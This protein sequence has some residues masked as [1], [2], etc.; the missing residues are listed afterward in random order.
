VLTPNPSL[1]PTAANGLRALA[2]PSSLRSSAAPQRERYAASGQQAM[3]TQQHLLWVRVRRCLSER[4]VG[5]RWHK[6]LDSG[7]AQAS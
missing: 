2:V 3:L 7:E 6:G 4:T 1:E 5:I